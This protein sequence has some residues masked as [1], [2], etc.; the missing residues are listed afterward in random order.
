M[1]SNTCAGCHGTLG[2]SAGGPMPIIGGLS[3]SYLN[4]SLSEF[5]SGKRSSTIM[6]RIAKGYSDLEL[7]AI[8]SFFA[9]QEWVPSTAKTNVAL[10]RKGHKIH[11]EQCATCHTDNGRG[12][13]GETP[14]LAGQW[15]DYLQIR[16]SDLRDAGGGMPQPM[17]MRVLCESLSDADIEALSRFYASQ[18]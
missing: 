2:A 5:K 10:A 16:L 9:Q 7:K 14:R 6:A 4:K 13:A 17:A 12:G 15:P 1:L 8:S 18:N 3:D 11:T